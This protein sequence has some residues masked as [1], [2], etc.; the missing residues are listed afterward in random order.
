MQQRPNG[1]PESWNIEATK[2][3]FVLNKYNIKD[4]NKIENDIKNEDLKKTVSFKS[5]YV[6]ESWN[7]YATTN[8]SQIENDFQPNKYRKN[9][10]YSST[11]ENMT[12]IL[13]YNR[14]RNRQQE[15]QQAE[16]YYN[17]LHQNSIRNRRQDNAARARAQ[18]YFDDNKHQFIELGNISQNKPKELFKYKKNKVNIFD[19]LN[20]KK[21]EQAKQ[22]II[23]PFVE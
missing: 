19:R 10:N 17:S 6:P 9:K 12:K 16:E 18:Q 7:L 1:I 8:I 11:H 20:Q 22:Q 4:N 21:Q 13:N 2:N 23:Q 14:A 3:N 15:Q 5:K